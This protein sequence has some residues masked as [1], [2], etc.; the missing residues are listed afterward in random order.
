MDR[1]EALRGR[2]LNGDVFD[3]LR[4]LCE[5]RI[6]FIRTALQTFSLLFYP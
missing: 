6:R 5:N 3:Y 2:V 4:V 1:G